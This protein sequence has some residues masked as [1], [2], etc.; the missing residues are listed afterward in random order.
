VASGTFSPTLRHGI[1]TAYVPA[2]LAAV[3]TQLAVSVRRKDVAA[4]VV[5]PPFVKQTSLQ[6]STA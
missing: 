5:R 1:A 2:E 4:T 6:A 3:G